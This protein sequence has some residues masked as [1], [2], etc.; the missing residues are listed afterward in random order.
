MVKSP[1]SG[2][3]GGVGG[4]KGEGARPRVGFLV[5]FQ[6]YDGFSPNPFVSAILSGVRAA[7]KTLSADLLVACGVGRDSAHQ[8]LIRPA[9]P[10]P[11]ADSDFVPVGPWNTDGLLVLNP[12]RSEARELYLGDLAAKG[13]PV[14]FIGTGAGSPSLVVDNAGGIRQSLQHLVGHGHRAIAFVAGDEQDPGDSL[15]RVQ[16][17]HDC[18]RSLGLSDDKRL[19]EYGKHWHGGGYDAMKRILA[20]GVPFTAVMCSNDESAGGALQALRESGRRVPADVAVTG[21]DDHAV[22]ATQ[23]PPLT[24]VHYPLVE[25]GHRALT[26]LHDAIL[27]GRLDLPAVVTVDTW[28][29]TRRSCGCLE[30]GP[31]GSRPPE[32]TKSAAAPGQRAADEAVA[33]SMVDALAGTLPLADK[34]EL[35]A[36]GQRLVAGFQQSLAAAGSSAFDVAL[37]D[38]M[39][40]IE[41]A[42]EDSHVWQA[43]LSALR[44][45]LPDLLQVNALRGGS[46]AAGHAHAED[47]LHYART[48]LSDSVRRQ[49]VRHLLLRAGQNDLMGRLTS[50]LLSAMDEREV[51]SIL[52][53]FVPSMGISGCTVAFFDPRSTGAGAC[54][55]VFPASTEGGKPVPFT[56]REFPPPGVYPPGEPLALALLPLG[57][58]EDKLGFVAFDAANLDPLAMIASQ[59]SAAVKRARLHAEVRSLSLTDALSGIS[60]RR[61]FDL[62]MEREIERSRRFNRDL[63]VIFIDVDL[64]KSY[65][66]TFGHIAGDEAIKEIARCIDAGIRELDV[67]SRFGGEEFAVILPETNAAGALLVAERIRGRVAGSDAFRRPLSISLG[68]V[69]HHGPIDSAAMLLDEADRALYRAKQ[70]G[71]NRVEVAG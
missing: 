5:G 61:Y 16:A 1:R 39:Q 53:E 29:V 37:V 47:L 43:A 18:V 20:S 9:W 15:C 46:S 33:A 4:V 44:A 32:E 63:S 38:L 6:V 34:R 70:A 40:A 25:T 59:V 55:S 21:F 26:L 51:L 64:F 35:H 58:Q 7:A 22:A 42:D 69:S 52:E 66:D 27:R 45:H 31:A 10:E 68:V 50:R 56:A 54:D 28:L 11:A 49:G 30:P 8:R 65:N 23:V 24:S 36:R 2:R 41:L 3:R 14:L 71:R 48:L 57:Y 12:L 60:N 19:L 17:Y 62:I 13:F 67:A